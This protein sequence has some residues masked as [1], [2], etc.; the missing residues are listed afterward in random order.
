MRRALPRTSSVAFVLKSRTDSILI[1][2]I[3]FCSFSFLS[4]LLADPA[5][6]EIP[7]TDTESIRPLATQSQQIPTTPKHISRPE[8]WPSSKKKTPHS[9]ISSIRQKPGSPL[10][11]IHDEGVVTVGFEEPAFQ[12]PSTA[13]PGVAQPPAV[14]QSPV[15][16]PTSLEDALVVARVGSEVVM[17]TDLLTPSVV[18]WLAKVTPGLKP[19][20]VRE[21]KLQIYRQLL[22]QHIESMLVYVDACRT[23]PEERL[24]EIE[25]KVREAFDQQQ[26]PKLVQEAG[27]STQGEY[28][29]YLR[30]RGQSLER[31]RKTYFE[32]ALAAQ[33]IQQKVST[34]EEIPHAQMIAIYQAHLKEYEFPAKT[35]FEQLTVRITPEQSREQAWQKLAGMG[36]RVINGE[37]FSDVAKAFSEGLTASGGGTYDWTIKGSLVSKAVDESIFTLPVGTLSSILDDGAVLHIVRVIERVEAGRVPFVEAQVGIKETLREQRRADRF[38]EYLTRLRNLTPV[39]TIFDNEPARVQQNVAGQDRQLR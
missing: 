29:L 10:D 20:Q 2:S 33:W 3:F 36:N 13:L 21:L 6:D 15:G 24:P 8:G 18:A 31:I 14:P 19:E 39:W 30:A 38:D 11:I 27:V 5:A 22:K 28:D 9:V 37:P 26:L 1:I 25:K 23:I 32:R 12:P 16:S 17:E 35:R 34:E 4:S 7:V